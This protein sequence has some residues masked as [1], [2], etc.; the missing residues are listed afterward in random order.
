V[1]AI[2]VDGGGGKRG[3]PIGIVGTTGQRA[4][5]GYEHVHLEL[6]RGT[7][8]NAV[9]DPRPRLA[10]CFDAQAAYATERLVLTYPL[11]CG[12]AAPR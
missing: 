12:G 9:E 7:D 1:T 11:R 8:V 5:P 4:W 6:Q 3:Q 10:G 2:S